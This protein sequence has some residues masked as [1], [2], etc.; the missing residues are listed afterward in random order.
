[1]VFVTATGH[2]LHAMN[3]SLQPRPVSLC[4]ERHHRQHLALPHPS[5]HVASCQ[6]PV[7]S[8]LSVVAATGRHLPTTNA[9]V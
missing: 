1:M 4:D 5:T 9:G 7:T 2:H 3:T 6:P 8:R